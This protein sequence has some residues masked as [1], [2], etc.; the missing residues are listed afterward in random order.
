MQR[1]E[2][3]AGL[4]LSALAG[5]AQTDPQKVPNTFLELKTWRLHNSAEEQAARLS[6]YLEGGLSPALS[7]SGGALIGAFS[8]VIGQDGPYYVTLAQY[9]SLNMFQGSLAH[10]ASDAAHLRELRKLS[11]GAAFPFVRVES[12]LLRSFDVFPAAALPDKSEKRPPRIF[13]LRTYE[14]QSYLTLTRKVGMF[15]NGEAQIFERLKMRPVFFGETLVG[16]RQ[17]NLTYI[18]S[19]DDLA[20]RDNLWHDFGSDPEWKALVAHPELKDPEIVANISNVILR[21]LAFSLIR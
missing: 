19:F 3:L 14:S 21:P 6:D 17:P 10:L 16:P 7:S 9:P 11:T 12:S 8:N 4:A 2:L 15:N 18:L 5:E 1:R 13:E 20:S